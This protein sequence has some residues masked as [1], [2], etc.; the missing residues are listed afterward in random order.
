MNYLK[1][2]SA[3][4]DFTKL[5]QITEDLKKKKKEQELKEKSI[6]E[7]YKKQIQNLVH[8]R[9]ISNDDK[10]DGRNDNSINFPGEKSKRILN[11][12][13]KMKNK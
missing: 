3:A 2:L 7:K 12:V 4:Q 13:N 6:E 11:V 1:K 8:N 10:N 9:K 5:H